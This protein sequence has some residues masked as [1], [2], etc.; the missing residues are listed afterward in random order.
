MGRKEIAK[1]LQLSRGELE[2]MIHKIN[3]EI[4]LTKNIVIPPRQA[5]KMMGMANLPIL[6]KRVNVA[7]DV[8]TDFQDGKIEL[9]PSYEYM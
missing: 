7:T 1:Q 8:I 4:K 9:C 6:S 2:P 3:G 5:L